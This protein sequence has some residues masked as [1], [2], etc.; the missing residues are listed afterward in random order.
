MK[1]KFS[2]IMCLL[3]SLTLVLSACGGGS[4]AGSGDKPNDQAAEQPKG[5]GSDKDQGADSEIISEGVI[6]ASDPG[7]SPEAAKNRKDTI[8][9][10]MLAPSGIINPI[11]AENVYDNYMTSAVFNSLL[12]INQDGTYS[13]DLAES[14]EVSEDKLTYTFK[15]KDGVKFSDGTPLTAEDVAFSI[16]LLHDKSYDGPSD[17]IA[18]ARIKGGQE[19]KDGKATSIEGIKVIDPKTIEITTTEISALAF[20]TIGG[21]GVMPKAYYGKDYKQGSLGYMRDL[22]TSPLGSGPFK[23]VKFVAGQE[24]VFAANEL[25]FEGKPKIEN[26]I[27]KFTTEETNVQ[28]LQTGETDMDN[29]S[30]NK[31]QVEQLKEMGFLDVTLFPT[32]GYGYIT[33]NHNRDEFKDKRV[34]QALAY[35][36]NRQEIV[37]AIYQGYAEVI[38]VP[39]SKVSWSYTDEVTH[40]NFDLDKAKQLLDEAGWKVGADGLREKD[41]KKFKINFTAT[42]PNPVNDAIIPVAQANYKE[43]GIEF[44]AEMM[45]FNAVVEKRKKGDFDMLFMAWQLTPDPQSGENVFKTGGSQNDV[46]YSNPKVDELFTK[47]GKEI[48]VEKRKPIFKE[49]YQELNE[50]LPYI[51][52]YQ[53][54]DMF[55]TNARIQGFDMSPY[56]NFTYDLAKIQIQ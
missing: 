49:L 4:N 46:G 28:L 37:D 41:G 15:L 5:E 17:V 7:K 11:F 43:L 32:N 42:T 39:Q 13:E 56:R 48:D 47:A 50:D 16:T 55:G 24:A 22:F 36:L 53:R 2:T 51:F 26:M 40:Y 29:I 23:L 45:D 34:R 31:D 18:H 38:D 27:Y 52:M 20:S 12:K 1:K 54:R 19:Y 30:V 10:G 35:G 25:Y 9:V 33:F 21:V 44:N 14:Y 6:K 8:I 3:L